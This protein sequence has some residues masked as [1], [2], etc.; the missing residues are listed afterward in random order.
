MMIGVDSVG[1]FIVSR[2]FN[3]AALL[4]E[5]VSSRLAASVIQIVNILL[6]SVMT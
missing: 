2:A 6:Q 1:L 5:E 3:G 4:T